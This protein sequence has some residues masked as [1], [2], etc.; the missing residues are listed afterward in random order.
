MFELCLVLCPYHGRWLHCISASASVKQFL[1]IVFKHFFMK[2]FTICLLLFSKCLVAQDC[3]TLDNFTSFHGIKFGEVF[4]DSLKKYCEIEY[5]EVRSDSM[6][7]IWQDQIKKSKKFS[8]WV[9]FRLPFS[10]VAFNTLKDGRVYSI[11]L[12]TPIDKDDS[13]LITQNKYPLFFEA[14]TEEITSIFGK[15]TKEEVSN[16]YFSKE[17]VRTWE[18]NTMKID[19][20]MGL[21]VFHSYSITITNKEL[22]KARKILKY[23]N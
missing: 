12:L 9:N 8:E 14:V 10:Y 20:E 11:L 4:P 7:T 19:F 22:D 2:L 13:L 23:T 3:K 18:C 15:M 21:T 5:N 6:F 1:C 16:D 17:L